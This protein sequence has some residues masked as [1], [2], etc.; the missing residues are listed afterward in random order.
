[1]AY[2]LGQAARATG[3]AKPTI[4]KAIQVGRISASRTADGAWAIDPAELHRVYPL[5]QQMNGQELRDLPG[6]PASA[7]LAE[8]LVERDRLVAEQAETIPRPARPPRC[9]SRGAPQ[10]DGNPH[11][12][13]RCAAVM[14]EALVPGIALLKPI[15]AGPLRRPGLPGD[16]CYVC[17]RSIA[18][19]MF[20]HLST[21]SILDRASAISACSRADHPI[22]RI[23][24]LLPWNLSPRSATL[25]A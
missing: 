2:T 8:L 1:M 4:A 10:V 7:A 24:D 25:A 23:A 14:V 12:P 20:C 11:R 19:P 5:T 6:E 22:N 21:V 13:T 18:W 9:R 15:P 17:S 16:V 3:K